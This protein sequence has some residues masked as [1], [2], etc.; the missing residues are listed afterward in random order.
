LNLYN[1]L[2]K[3]YHKLFG[4]YKYCLSYLL[5]NEIDDEWT[6]LDVGCGRCSPLKKIKKESYEVGVD[7]YKPYISKSKEQSIH[8]K[9]VFGDVRA[10]LF[11]TNS[12]D[13]AIAIEVLEHLNREDG[14][15]ML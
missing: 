9:Y 15:K 12:F 6:I 8:D 4:K 11:K 10:L 2:L 5:S 1:L 7:H 3:I 13:C 14:L